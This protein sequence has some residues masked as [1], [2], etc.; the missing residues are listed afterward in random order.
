MRNA[1]VLVVDK[2]YQKYIPY[3]ACF[4]SELNNSCDI[5]IFS[6]GSKIDDRIKELV[7]SVGIDV[8]FDED[9]FSKYDTS[10]PHLLKSLRWIINQD[11]VSGYNNIYIGDVDILLC[12]EEDDL[13]VQHLNHC[14]KTQL[15]YSNSVRNIDP[16]KKRLTGLHFIKC[17]EY[18][19]QTRATIEKYSRQLMQSGTRF[20]NEQNLYE[21]IRQSGLGFP[22]KWWRPH[23]GIHLGL[24]RKGAVKISPLQWSVNNREQ[25]KAYYQCFL[26][27]KR[28]SDFLRTLCEEFPI[29]EIKNMEISLRKEFEN[30]ELV[31]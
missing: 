15:P 14:E 3:Y 18:Y 19:E 8:V 12:K 4:A 13:F 10:N 6:P 24:W 9:F 28:T 23:H 27:M 16:T 5:K 31:G 20:H 17:E 21:I 2:K 11:M 29:K 26:E 22:E 30:E 7:S 1:L 25:Y